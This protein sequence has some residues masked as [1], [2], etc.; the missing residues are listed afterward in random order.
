MTSRKII[1][2]DLDG[3]L[4]SH[5]T[6]L[7]RF[8]KPIRG[9]REA[10]EELKKD[11]NLIV[12]T[13]R[14]PLFKRSS[15]KWIKH[16]FPDCFSSIEFVRYKTPFG[17]RTSKAEICKRINAGCIIDDKLKNVED[18]SKAG[19]KVYFFGPDKLYI[20]NIQ[21]RNVVCVEDWMEVL[22]K[23]T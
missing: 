21:S 16:H 14:Y 1:A 20:D 15:I 13:A 22:N 19:I 17:P 7:F 3:V 11:Y 9:S 2:V 18:C 6:A 4:G 5:L 23:L 12:V 10:I 8:I